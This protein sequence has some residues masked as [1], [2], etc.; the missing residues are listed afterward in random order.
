MT[1]SAPPAR[2]KSRLRPDKSVPVGTPPENPG[3]STRFVGSFREVREVRRRVVRN[4]GIAINGDEE[5]AS[6]QLPG[7]IKAGNPRMRWRGP[8]RRDGRLD[9]DTGA[10]A[11]RSRTRI[12][13][14]CAGSTDSSSEC[15]RGHVRVRRD[16]GPDFAFFARRQQNLPGSRLP[17]IY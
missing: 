1:T 7:Y 3:Q 8:I 15:M 13:A 12:R 14:A 9:P 5:G 11:D 4:T 16:P 10:T 17:F 2:D 6:G